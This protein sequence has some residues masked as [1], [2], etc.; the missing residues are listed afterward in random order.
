MSWYSFP[1]PRVFSSTQYFSAIEA[2][3]LLCVEKIQNIDKNPNLFS[4]KPKLTA[5]SVDIIRFQ[6]TAINRKETQK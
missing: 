2:I 5:W 3:L 4:N 6:P 1:R